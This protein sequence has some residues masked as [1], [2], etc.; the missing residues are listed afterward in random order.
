MPLLKTPANSHSRLPLTLCCALV[1]LLCWNS[2]PVGAQSNGVDPALKEQAYELYKV[3]KFEDALPLFEKLNAQKPG[4]PAILEG[5]SYCVLEHAATLADPSE[6]KATRVKARKLAVEAQSAGDK[7]N[8]LG[9]I[10]SLP[11]DGSEAAFSASS[12]VD[13]AMRAGEAAFAKGD[14]DA[15]LLQYQKALVL[16]PKEYDAALYMGDVYYKKGS[17]EDAGRWY[18][19][20]VEINPNRETA[21]RYWGD[22]L[23]AQG[24]AN[25]AKTKFVQA[26]VAAPYD[27]RSWMGLMQ[28]AQKQKV[29]LAHP[30][31]NPPGKVEDKGKD[32]NGKG[33]INITIDPSMLGDNT[34]HDGTDAWFIYT[35]SK[36]TWHGERFQKEFPTEKQYRHTLAEEV[37][38][39]QLVVNQVR[40]ELKEKKIKKLDPALTDLVKLSDEGLLEPFVL[41][42]KADSGIAVDYPPYRDAHRDKIAQYIN[43]WIVRPGFTSQ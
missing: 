18:L 7:S 21:Y 34:K 12:D 25:D 11:E 15:A 6:R 28:W 31:I 14:Y 16:D 36:A 20:A 33:Q 42:S 26:I 29:G 9:I 2:S 40:D 3:G 8:L 38:G 1:L 27:K 17:H 22:D 43:E 41:I 23:M 13:A 4:D 35:L 19:R 5:Y 37:D 30:A 39:Y 10:L 32:A 24:R